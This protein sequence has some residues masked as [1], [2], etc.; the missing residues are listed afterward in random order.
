MLKTARLTGVRFHDG[1]H[2]AITTMQEKAIPD[3][4]IRAQVGHVSEE[5]MKTYSQIR[6]KSLEQAAAALEPSF[7][8]DTKPDSE[9]RIQ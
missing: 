9:M 3:W 7:L 5:M 1:R 4:V 8:I 2:T 6:R